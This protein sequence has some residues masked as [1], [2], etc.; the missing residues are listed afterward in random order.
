M[1]VCVCECDVGFLIK[2][3]S[4]AAS[5]TIMH[6][7]FSDFA[8]VVHCVNFMDVVHFANY[9]HFI[10]VMDFKLFAD[11]MNCMHF[12]NFELSVNFVNLLNFANCVFVFR[13][14]M[15]SVHFRR[16]S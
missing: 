3:R 14:F 10:N 4:S 6:V 12:D 16:I 13:Y 2:L 7:S 5:A 11:F 1:R 9:S 8:H 15:N